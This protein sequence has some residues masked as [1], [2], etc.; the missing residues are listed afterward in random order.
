MQKKTNFFLPA[1]RETVIKFHEFRAPVNV[2]RVKSK[3]KLCRKSD[4]IPPS[5]QVDGSVQGPLI[6]DKKGKSLDRRNE[7]FLLLLSVGGVR[8]D[9]VLLAY[10]IAILEIIKKRP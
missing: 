3:F 9:L 4:P 7:F 1:R 5:V 10:F 8:E 2:S 6:P